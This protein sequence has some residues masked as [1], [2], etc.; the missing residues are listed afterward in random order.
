[1]TSKNQGFYTIIECDG[2]RKRTHWGGT[3]K[4]ND[5]CNLLTAKFGVD[6]SR[7]QSSKILVTFKG[8]D[9]VRHE[10]RF[11][12]QE[13][14]DRKLMQQAESLKVIFEPSNQATRQLQNNTV[15]SQQSKGFSQVFV[16]PFSSSHKPDDHEPAA[17]IKHSS[18]LKA[19]LTF[20]NSQLHASNKN[21][22]IEEIN[23]EGKDAEKFGRFENKS[24]I[25][26]ST[27]R[28]K[29]NSPKKLVLQPFTL[30]NLC[31]YLGKMSKVVVLHSSR[32]QKLLQNTLKLVPI[33][34]KESAPIILYNKVH[35]LDA[36]SVEL[37]INED[38]T[39]I[40]KHNEN[41]PIVLGLFS[42]AICKPNCT[43]FLVQKFLG[44][45]SNYADLLCPAVDP[46]VFLD[47]VKVLDQYANLQ[48]EAAAVLGKDKT[49]ISLNLMMAFIT[50]FYKYRMAMFTKSNAKVLS[51]KDPAVLNKAK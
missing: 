23:I 13:F 20:P 8:A 1:M 42:E 37:N 17:G 45:G 6:K 14:L 15:A 31:N 18:P 22:E 21:Q 35:S 33:T 3:M 12:L 41:L 4:M 10:N 30:E 38:V 11:S 26:D 50:S 40:L 51:S 27:G 49:P 47:I 24:E 7:I 44:N 5:F 46:A 25:L 39:F 32:P 2:M 29:E 16:Q 19:L 48:L 34:S 36:E 9:G 43:E 28:S